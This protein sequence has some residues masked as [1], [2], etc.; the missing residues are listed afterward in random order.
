MT[1]LFR[2]FPID[3]QGSVTGLRWGPNVSD[4][5][6]TLMAACSAC[7]QLVAWAAGDILKLPEINEAF[8]RCRDG[9]KRMIREMEEPEQS[10]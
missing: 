2:H 1:A 9:Y 3:E 7:V 8:S 4:I 5:E 10:F 6:D